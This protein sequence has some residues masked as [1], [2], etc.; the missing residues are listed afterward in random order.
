MSD[1][2]KDLF[3]IVAVSIIFV[4]ILACILWGK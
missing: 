1:K 4:W 2:S 3:S